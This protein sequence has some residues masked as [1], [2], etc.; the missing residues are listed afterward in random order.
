MT[1]YI[2]MRNNKQSSPLS[3][4][5]LLKIGFKPYDLIWIDG[6]SAMWRYPSEVTELK[7]FAAAIEEQ[8]YDRFYS[9]NKSDEKKIQHEN[10]SKEKQVYVSL[11][12][13]MNKEIAKVSASVQNTAVTKEYLPASM[14]VAETKYSQPLDDIKEMYVANLRDKK[15]KTAEQLF[16]SMSIK[17]ISLYLGLI[18]IGTLIGYFFFYSKNYPGTPITQN[19]KKSNEA[20]I[21]VSNQSKL[22]SE[23]TAASTDEIKFKKEEAQQSFAQD[24][25]ITVPEKKVSIEKKAPNESSTRFQIKEK[26]VPLNNPIKTK[27]VSPGVEINTATGERNKKTRNETEVSTTSASKPENELTGLVSVKSNNYQRGAFG[28]IRNLELTLS[29]QS[30][31]LLDKV[32]I[33]LQYIK[34]NEQPLRSEKILFKSIPPRGVLTIAI[35]PSN[36]GIKVAYKIFSIESKE[37]TG[38]TAGL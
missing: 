33:E 6:K 36:R 7:E 1:T 28:G 21:P 8:P 3:L 38:E 14:P 17:R 9:N 20:V 24:A 5:E 26:G 29:N 12:D 16:F 2:L 15:R 18:A 4:T 13:K 19:E 27:E 32:I 37:L 30:K 22:I 35:P 23:T 11:P 25:G 31:Y 10:D 34:P